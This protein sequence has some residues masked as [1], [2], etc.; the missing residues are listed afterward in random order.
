MIPA[1]LQVNT[2]TLEP[3]A[4]RNYV[5]INSIRKK[6][7]S[8]WTHTKFRSCNGVKS[9]NTYACRMYMSLHANAIEEGKNKASFLASRYTKHN[10]PDSPIKTQLI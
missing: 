9:N 7:D 4:L 10:V 6:M 3:E 5:F 2:A 1:F 8:F